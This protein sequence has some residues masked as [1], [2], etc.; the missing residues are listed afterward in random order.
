MMK[1]KHLL[2]ILVV[3]GLA[4]SSSCTKTSS[5]AAARIVDEDVEEMLQGNWAYSYWSS[6][7]QNPLSAAPCYLYDKANSTY[8]GDG[9]VT[10]NIDAAK[11]EIHWSTQGD[12]PNMPQSYIYSKVASTLGYKPVSNYTFL[13]LDKAGQLVDTVKIQALTE[14]LLVLKYVTGAFGN[15]CQVDSL[16]R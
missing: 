8:F 7:P 10:L 2:Y 4:G 13:L 12:F 9:I 6:C 5:S 1:W 16:R 15:T 3:A 14:H 11:K